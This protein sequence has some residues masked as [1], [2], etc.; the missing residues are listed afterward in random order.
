MQVYE[1][2]AMEIARQ[3]VTKAFGLLGE[4]VAKFVATLPGLGIE[5][6]GTHHEASA[7]GMADGYARVTGDVGVA[8]VSRGCGFTNAYTSLINASK[9]RSAV[10]LFTG[11]S[12]IGLDDP[13]IAVSATWAPKHVDQGAALTAA[14]VRHVRLGS[15]STAVA[16]V[17][18]VFD[19]ARRGETFVVNIPT[20]VL[21]AEAG[22][23]NTQLE[24]PP[25]ATFGEPDA[26]AISDVA[27]LLEADW[28]ARN[29]VILAGRG[30]VRAG[31]GAALERLGELTGAAL[32]TT[33]LAKSMFRGSPFDLGIMGTFA[34]PTA[35][36]AL[37]RADVLLV[38]GASL[39]RLTTFGGELAPKAKVIQFDDDPGA[40]GRYAQPFLTIQG[41]ARLAAIALVDELERRG[42]EA[43]GYR[44]D[45]FVEK[46]AAEDTRQS[47]T[48]RSTDDSMDPRTLLS[49][50][51]TI[52]PEAATVVVD[53]GHH[54]SFQAT[55]LDVS[56]PSRWI[57]AFDY[58]AVGSGTPIA[59]GAAVAA[60]DQLTV[61][62]IGD[63]GLMMT[64][65]ELETAVRYEIPLLVLVLNDAA[66]GA[67]VHF[68]QLYGM[69]DET[70]RFAGV[71]FAD[72]ASAMGA[73]AMTVTSLRDLDELKTR[74]G[75]ADAIRG[76]LVVDC[77]L[78][79]D[80]RADFID[81]WDRLMEPQPTS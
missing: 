56:E 50:V 12:A 49:A 7:A 65:G 15:P 81:S 66:L 18:A 24:L 4:D 30:A 13:S 47:F 17:A 77:K 22:Q 28:A 42:H 74:L 44:T 45:D 68:L 34:T 2:V 31:A 46:V 54:G 9:A 60:P 72:I 37:N 11:D 21:V 35:I 3:G 39:N 62:G 43:L 76:P 58:P 71:A 19:A 27:D 75:D 53:P 32:T 51:D 73:E 55:Y 23:D 69:P 78:T 57:W 10:V 61:L 80:V 1:A 41:D 79:T 29:P 52:L 48:D 5:Y 25:P 70:A 59:L 16:D 20:D 38:F 6:Y 8:L 33:L 36:D 26:K 67:E 40:F 14:G 63:G 64:L